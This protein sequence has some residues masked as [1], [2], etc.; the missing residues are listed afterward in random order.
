MVPFYLTVPWLA[1][2]GQV[3]AP[4]V[5]MVRYLSCGPLD[6]LLQ[7]GLQP[8]HYGFNGLWKFLQFGQSLKKMN[9]SNKFT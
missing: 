5:S 4:L 9:K 2:L 6:N 1:L 8:L 3:F 7:L